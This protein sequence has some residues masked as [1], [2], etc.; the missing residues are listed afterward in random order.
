M[1]TAT[2]AALVHADLDVLWS[3]LLDKLQSDERVLP[4]LD[5]VEIE[6]AEE[7][8]APSSSGVTGKRQDRRL[9][10][11]DGRVVEERITV[12][13]ERRNILVELRNDARYTGYVSTVLFPCPMPEVTS[14]AHVLVRTLD[15]RARRSLSDDEIEEGER[16]AAK[17]KESTLGL[18]HEAESLRW[19]LDESKEPE[20]E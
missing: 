3:L 9:F 16:M 1:P 15:W 18:K 19:S 13:E 8:S 2:Y 5:R 6:P 17:I 7:T 20:Y 14:G 10:F 12:D 4:G 11:T